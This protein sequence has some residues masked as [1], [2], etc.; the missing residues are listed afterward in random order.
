M[1]GGLWLLIGSLVV[2]FVLLDKGGL[3]GTIW[4]PV[5]VAAA[6]Y[7]LLAGKR[8]GSASFGMLMLAVVALFIIFGMSLK[9]G[10][11]H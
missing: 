1:K 11:M 3:T 6:V 7:G 2:V 9:T 8:R 10:I 4:L 5:A